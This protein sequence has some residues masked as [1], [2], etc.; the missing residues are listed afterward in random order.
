MTK[1]TPSL[2]Q[3]LDRTE[4]RGAQH[5]FFPNPVGPV[6]T[7]YDISGAGMHLYGTRKTPGVAARRHWIPEKPIWLPVC[8]NWQSAGRRISSRSYEIFIPFEIV[9]VVASDL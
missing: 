5:N 9:T 7:F 3:S 6:L 1:L 4:N 8:A 2:E